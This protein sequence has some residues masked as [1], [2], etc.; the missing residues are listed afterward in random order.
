MCFPKLTGNT[1]SR[2]N[3][4]SPH[5][6]RFIDRVRAIGC[7]KIKRYIVKVN[8]VNVMMCARC[9]DT[10]HRNQQCEVES[11]HVL[12]EGRI[13]DTSCYYCNRSHY[14]VRAMLNCSKCIDAF[15]RYITHLHNQGR[16]LMTDHND[17]IITIGAMPPE[18]VPLVVSVSQAICLNSVYDSTGL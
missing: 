14:H 11:F 8:S 7:I 10:H 18:F 12:F 15:H 4:V 17:I 13:I 2:E 3:S 1:S 9:K 16:S 5:A 6:S